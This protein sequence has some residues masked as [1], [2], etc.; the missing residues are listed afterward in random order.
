MGRQPSH[1]GT[2]ATVT[3]AQQR[4]HSVQACANLLVYSCFVALRGA[5]SIPN[6]RPHSARQECSLLPYTMQV[7]R[8]AGAVVLAPAVDTLLA[9]LQRELAHD[10]LLQF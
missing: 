2:P 1:K 4:Q 5:F 6:W 7:P 3:L 10:I 9:V 8:A